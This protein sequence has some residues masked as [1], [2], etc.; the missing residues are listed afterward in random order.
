M[1]ML[2]KLINKYNSLSAPIRMSFWLL[3][4]SFL[5]KGIGMITTPIFT[6]IMEDAEFGRFSVYSSW[7][8]VI[9]V[10]TTLNISGNCF[11]R[12]LV[13]NDDQKEKYTSSLL[14]LTTL[15]LSFSFLFFV[16]F[17]SF[18]EKITGLSLFLIAMMFIEMFMTA[19]FNFWMN[20]QRVEFKYR[21]VVIVTLIFA[22]IRPLAAVIAITHVDNNV[23][24]EARVAAVA[25]V[26]V[27]LF[28]WIYIYLFLKG[29]QFYS[30]P[31]KES[32]LFCIP[33]IPHYLSNV[34]LAQSDRIMIDKYCGT[35]E[36]G[37]YSVAYSIAMVMLI[38]NSAVSSSFTPWLYKKIKDNQLDR[39]GKIS[40]SLL[41]I[42]AVLN[43]CLVA[44]APELMKIMGPSSYASA[45]WA[46]PPVTISVYFMFMYD[47]FAAF[48]F[49]YKK[50][51]W[52]TWATLG[53]ALLNIVL[54]YYCIRLFG[55]VAAG[56][57]TLICYILYGLLHY[58]FMKRVTRE[59]LEGYKVYDGKVILG[60]GICLIVLSTIMTALY[61]FLAIRLVVLAAIAVATFILR[62][63][64]IGVFATL[65]NNN[66]DGG[67]YDT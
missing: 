28:S 65:K 38:F 3:I 7:L 17:N 48:Q 30:K 18:I 5:Q 31:W 66:T 26:D 56:Y 32:I 61:D 35:A 1:F 57:T 54:N 15:L 16:L 52:I 20:R 62:K 6:R 63:K 43:F 9:T 39:I 49:Y 46:I 21:A 27:L 10:F 55:Y 24:V 14:G 51:K 67:S 45:T 22:I 37:Y 50:T 59:Y 19:T 41:A 36:A 12:G 58:Y 40:Y 29:K 60:I 34:L 8:N 64:L 44:I 11:T 23:Q 2:R 53:S 47:L 25:A 42:I 13:V 4:C 33:L